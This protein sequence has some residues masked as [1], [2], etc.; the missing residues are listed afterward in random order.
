MP[1]TLVVA[2]GNAHKRSEIAAMLAP[3]R[4]EVV[5][6]RELGLA[7]AEET[8]D[9]FAANALLK[10]IGGWRGTRR[11]CLADDSGL[12]VDALGGLPGVRSARFAGE[13]ATD[14]ENNALL[15]ARLAGVPAAARTARFVSTLA[16]VLPPEL[17]ANAPLGPW[18]RQPLDSEGAVAF[19]V[20]G[21][22]EGRIIDEPRGAAGF[23]YDPH[24]LYEPAGR[25][26][27][28]LAA[29]EKHA[30]SHRGQAMARL[31]E[32]LRATFG[33]E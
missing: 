30:V 22:V 24:F 5:T 25:T 20:S 15:I 26:F 8:G 10:A 21:Q 7:D 13:G 6:T 17:A 27:A 11:P 12:I 19:T 1:E 16:L 33:A 29:A 18:E 31:S 4:V 14:A 28:E 23:G 2:T 9:T 32:L 3:H